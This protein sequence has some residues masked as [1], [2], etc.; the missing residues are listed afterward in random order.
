M[1]QD[2]PQTPAV[3]PVG[4]VPVGHADFTAS[5]TTVTDVRDSAA[6]AQDVGTPRADSDADHSSGAAEPSTERGWWMPSYQPSV[7]Q[8]AVTAGRAVPGIT[9]PVP[10]PVEGRH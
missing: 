10:D 3:P 6:R 7:V 8:P 1:S 4:P 9:D 2:E 5:T